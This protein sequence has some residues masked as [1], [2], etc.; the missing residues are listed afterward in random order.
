VRRLAAG[1]IQAA[2]VARGE[3]LAAMIAGVKGD[4]D[5]KPHF[6]TSFFVN[7]WYQ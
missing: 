3:I 6:Q 2:K 1:C 7:K 4:V 5:P